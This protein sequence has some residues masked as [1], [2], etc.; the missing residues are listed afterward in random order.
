MMKQGERLRLH[1]SGKLVERM[2]AGEKP[3][4]EIN[5]SKMQLSAYN[6]S[7]LS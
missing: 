6:M 1:C 7:G 4:Q 3:Y 2:A 5:P